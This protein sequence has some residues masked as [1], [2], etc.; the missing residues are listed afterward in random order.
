MRHPDRDVGP[1]LQSGAA[2][3]AVLAAIRQLNARVT[4][5][6]RGAY[7][8][9]SVPE[10]CVVTRAAVEENL[11]RPF[12]IP[13]DLEKIMTSFQGEMRL[14][15]DEATWAFKTPAGSP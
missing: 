7:L 10:R 13:S 15:D 3:D 9:I 5:L 4:V 1:V 8:R 14:S 11:G 2:A 12:L 6:D